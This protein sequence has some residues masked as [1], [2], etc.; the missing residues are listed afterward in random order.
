MVLLSE[1]FTSCFLLIFSYFGYNYYGIEGLGVAYFLTCLI[2]FLSTYFWVSNIYDF[3]YTISFKIIFIIKFIFIF[4]CLFILIEFIN[5][6]L[7]ISIYLTSLSKY[8]FGIIFILFSI[9]YSIYIINKKLRI[10][11]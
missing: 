8:L 2:S 7:I 3:K 4:F 11:G 10:F 9:F 1:I 6:I 5:L